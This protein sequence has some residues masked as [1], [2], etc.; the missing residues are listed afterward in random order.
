M[1]DMKLVSRREFV[2]AAGSAAAA[3][4]ILGVAP[5][6]AQ[7]AKRRYAI[8]GTGDRAQGMWGRPL[9]QKYSDVLEFVGLCDINPKRAEIAREMIGVSCPIFVPEI[10]A[11]WPRRIRHAPHRVFLSV[12]SRAGSF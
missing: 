7:P 9:A 5:G 3:T 10:F 8:V 1:S 12:A 6:M 2:K 4:S 11:P